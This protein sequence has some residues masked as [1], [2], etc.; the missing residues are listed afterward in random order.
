MKEIRPYFAGFLNFVIPGLG[1][2]F[3]GKKIRAAGFFLVIYA[4]FFVG[5]MM[6]G[7]L[8]NL[9][10]SNILY[11]LGA[12]GQMGLGLTFFL[13]KLIHIAPLDTSHLI[14]ITFGYGNTFLVSS[15]L[16]N[17]LIIMDAY[18]IAAGRKP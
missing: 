10:K 4:M 13:S 16:M 6:K 18:D 15:G 14:S 5:V 1:H 8:F 9:D 3:L 12:L 2:F 11:A 7:S 17:G